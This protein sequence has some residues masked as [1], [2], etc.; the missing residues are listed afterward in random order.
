MLCAKVM[1]FPELC[2]TH[3]SLSTVICLRIPG[4]DTAAE[5]DIYYL[6]L[7][8][9]FNLIGDEFADHEPG[10]SSRFA[11]VVDYCLKIQGFECLE[12]MQKRSWD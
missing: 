3:G 8:L 6:N 7:S 12:A 1:F 5:I 2:V 4:E 9:T 11:F 10:F